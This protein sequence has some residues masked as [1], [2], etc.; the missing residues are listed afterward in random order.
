MR[1]PNSRPGFT[2]TKKT[3]NPIRQFRKVKNYQETI[4]RYCPFNQKNIKFLKSNFFL[5]TSPAVVSAVGEGKLGA[6]ALTHGDPFI[7]HVHRCLI[8]DFSAVQ[9]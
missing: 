9:R 8:A 2:R 5:T 3:Q 7:R 6:A 4:S 1:P